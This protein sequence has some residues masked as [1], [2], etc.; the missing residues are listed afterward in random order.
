MQSRINART[1]LYGEQY[2]GEQLPSAD[3]GKTPEEQ[4]VIGEI[5]DQFEDLTRRQGRLS[6][7]ANDIAT[8]KNEKR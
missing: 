8:G 7:V 2:K 6:K 1:K 3:T 4:K 5:R